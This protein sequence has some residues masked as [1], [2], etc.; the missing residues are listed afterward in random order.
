VTLSYFG[1]ES[2]FFGRAGGT[3]KVDHCPPLSV[4][5]WKKFHN[6]SK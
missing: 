6:F 1:E 5:V 4:T 2:S 3:M